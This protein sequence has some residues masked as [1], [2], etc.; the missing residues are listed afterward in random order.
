[1]IE[2]FDVYKCCVVDYDYCC[3]VVEEMLWYCSV[4]IFFCWVIEDCEYWGVIFFKDV[5]IFF[6]VSVVGCDLGVFVDVDWFEL[7]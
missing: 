5:M 6:L 3:K 1:M 4:L 2:F 7:D